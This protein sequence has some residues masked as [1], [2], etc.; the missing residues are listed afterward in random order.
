MAVSTAPEGAAPRLE[1]ADLRRVTD[2]AAVA[3]ALSAEPG[4]LPVVGHARA[5]EAVELAVRLPHPGCNIFALGPPGVGKQR[6]VSALLQAE[7][8]QRPPPK[9]WVYVY[10]FSDDGRRPRALSLPAGR[11]AQLR[12]DMD[13][14]IE[15]LQAA[16][17]AVFE[18]EDYRS[19]RQMIED[20]FKGEHERMLEAADQF[21]RSRGIAI[22]RLPMGMALAPL[23][24]GEVITPDAFEK[25]SESEQAHYRAEMNSVQDKLQ[26]V[27]R[28]VPQ[29]ESQRREAVRDLNR[30]V[31]G[32]AIAHLTT[33]LRERYADLEEVSAHLVQVEADLVENAERFLN[34]EAGAPE[35]MAEIVP[36]RMI[37]QAVFRRYR[38]NLLVDHT[39][40]KQAPVVREEHPTLA[41]LIGRIEYRSQ[42]GSLTTDF[43]LIKPGALHRANGGYLLLDARRVLLQPM[44]WEELNRALRT[45]QIRIQSLGEVVGMTPPVSLEPEPI[46]LDVK[47]VLLGERFLYYL[48][49][50]HD[51]D[52]PELYKIAADFD[53]SVPRTPESE[54][55]MASIMARVA[56]EAGGPKL[57][58]GGA[59][60]MVEHAA[61][62]AGDAGRIACSFEILADVV[63]EA[64]AGA[65]KAGRA[66]IEA[67]DVRAAVAARLRRAARVPERVREE[68]LARRLMIDL[69][70]ARVGQINGLSVVQLGTE[71]F[72]WPARITA[73]VRLGSGKVMDIERE[74]ELGGP[75]HSKGVLILS[76]FLGSR[77]ARGAPLAL[78]ASLVFEQSYAGVEGDSASMA[79]LLALLSAIAEVPLRQDLAITGS[80]NQHGDSQA[81]GGVNEKIEGFFDLCQAAGLSGRQGIVIPRANVGHLMLR[82][83][84]VEA[85]AAGRFHIHAY[86][87]VDEAAAL[88]TGLAAG[89]QGKDGAYPPD[90]LNGRVAAG[91]DA[92]AKEAIRL[93]ALGR[94]ESGP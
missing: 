26:S 16:I 88:M 6:I 32:F 81:I 8:A 38:V 15:E 14:L 11:G 61:R 10:D 84:V 39:D 46:P 77:Y 34:P 9:E 71:S 62:M 94:K 36:A 90:S 83:D 50:A 75:I 78:S 48:L 82:E 40:A 47:I 72:G 56:A 12:R 3:P 45:K 41:N 58:P 87:S 60:R 80:V 29:I 74:V 25:L 49:A 73:R 4:S 33:E 59:A 28:R 69:D 92:F 17:P 27:L 52:F 79:E 91:L 43:T 21:A 89:A 63:R 5:R 1:V 93:S 44:A 7:A 13:K 68:M 37:K 66:A 20:R 64:G 30:E 2:P 54:A 19:R 76:G 23:V 22:I 51:S 67:E 85:V 70:G 57:A 55:S 65:A 31:M 35:G 42:F 53:D 86:A 24:K 18:S